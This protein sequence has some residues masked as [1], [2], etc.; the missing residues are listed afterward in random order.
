MATVFRRPWNE[1]AI[2]FQEAQTLLS[3]DKHEMLSF[4]SSSA[5]LQLPTVEENALQK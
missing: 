1:G 3:G 4:F 5:K 2:L